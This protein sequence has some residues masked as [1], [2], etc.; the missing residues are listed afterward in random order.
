MNS[1]LQ[2][3]WL[4]PHLLRQNARGR[5]GRRGQQ[6]GVHTEPQSKF[7]QYIYQRKYF[8]TFRPPFKQ[9][10]TFEGLCNGIEKKGDGGDA[11]KSPALALPT[12][13]VSKSK[14]SQKVA[15]CIYWF[16]VLFPN[17]SLGEQQQQQVDRDRSRRLHRRQQQQQQQQQP[18]PRSAADH[19][20]FLGRSASEPLFVDIVLHFF[21][22][23]KHIYLFLPQGR[24]PAEEELHRH[25]VGEGEAEGIFTF[26]VFIYYL[27]KTFCAFFK[28][29]H[30]A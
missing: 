16:F 12:A 28:D 19:R 29:F 5:R 25:S 3:R 15:A 2:A 18:P 4:R 9:Q 30:L 22:I 13:V 1:Y 17:I 11:E 10:V 21:L 24:R 26:L 23:K 14:F 27:Q 20:V 7:P 8:D 6:Q